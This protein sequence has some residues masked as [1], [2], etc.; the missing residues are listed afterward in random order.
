[1]KLPGWIEGCTGA[2]PAY[3]FSSGGEFPDDLSDYAL[4]IHCGGCM[5]SEKEMQSRLRRVKTCGVPIV[6]YG[7]AI[8]QMHG[9]LARSLRPF[10]EMLK[11]LDQ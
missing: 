7:V 1:M 6:N 5:L 3:S 8:A 11:L 4:V 10:P 9:I 2:K